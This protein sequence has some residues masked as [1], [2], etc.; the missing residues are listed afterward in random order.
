MLIEMK[1]ISYTYKPGTPYE[2]HA[3]EGVSLAVREGEYLGLIGH[4]G[5]GKSTLVQHLNGLLIPSAGEMTVDGTRY[6]QGRKP[7]RALRRTVG[8]VFQ[9][10]EDQL[11]EETVFEDVAFAPRNFG[12]EEAEIRERVQEALQDVGLDYDT[13]RDRSPFSLSGG[14]MRRA[15]IAGVL[16]A[17]PRV[18]VLDEPTAGLDP[19]GRDEILERIARLRDRRGITVILVSHSMDD[20][21]AYAERVLVM[22]TGRIAFEGT[23]QQV[24]Q[25]YR[26]L[27]DMGLDIPVVTQLMFALRE[28][29]FPVSTEIFT[30]PEALREILAAREAM[31]G[32]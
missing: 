22:D 18:L 3:L 21:A 25:E 28:K 5:C 20:I 15:A 10:P 12:L 19:R 6:F 7:D 16:A 17:R 26:M 11:F 4:T 1:D 14:E 13:Y 23:P 2:C 31:A 29:G 27:R 9:Y 8:M 32:A 30:A 24:F